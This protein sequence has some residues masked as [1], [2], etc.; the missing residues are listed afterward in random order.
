[1][2]DLKFSYRAPCGLSVEEEYDT[3]MIFTDD[4]DTE[5]YPK[6]NLSYG[7]V[8]ARFFENPLLDRHFET[9][10]DL[11]NHCVNIMRGHK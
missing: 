5:V 11:Y 4:V 3:I 1:M 7:P 2:T 9:I 6:K 8:D 10:K